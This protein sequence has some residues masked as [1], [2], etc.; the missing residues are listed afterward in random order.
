MSATSVGGRRSNAFFELACFSLWG[1][2]VSAYQQAK[3][4]DDVLYRVLQRDLSTFLDLAEQ[5]GRPLPRHVERELASYLACGIPGEGFT[6]L[7]CTDCPAVRVVP[8][9]CKGRGFCPSCV[10]RQMNQQAAHLVDRVFPEN[11]PVRQWVLT[12]P[13]PLRLRMAWDIDLRRAVHKVFR[14][15]VYRWYRRQAEAPKGDCGSVT[16]VQNFGSALNLN[17]HFHSIVLDGV[18]VWDADA[19]PV[20]QR[21]PPPTDAEVQ[22]VVDEIAVRVE[23]L[24]RRRGLLDEENGDQEE[25]ESEDGQL[26]MMA[27]SAAGRTA[28]GARA[29]R[30][31]RSLQGPPRP[32]GSLPPK[33]ASS[34]WFNLHAGVAIAPQDPEALER[35]IRYTAR[36][37]LSLDRVQEL[38]DGRVM[39]RFKRAWANG[40]AAVILTGVELLER[41]AALVPRPRAQRVLYGGILASAAAWRSL[42]VPKRPGGERRSRCKHKHGSK[43][44]PYI[45]W[46]DLLFRVFG[47]DAFKCHA[48]DG[49]MRV[50]AVVKGFWAT[51]RVLG[52]LRISPSG[53][54][55]SR[56]PPLGTP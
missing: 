45:K 15:V 18:F 36:P 56:A 46:K 41:L 3:R 10:G 35:L 30:R 39:V 47:V 4:G 44:S 8:F 1:P 23:R 28:L 13:F 22:E 5:R 48:C 31:P 53:P 33:C 43:D 25:E 16:F 55:P 49:R 37:P 19:G 38:D 29:G 21:V 26:L 32:R 11:V 17:V 27:A 51:R 34:G 42:V 24:L 20:F 54:A 40:T 7:R 2:A 6:L 9:T 14:G 12:F 52:C 50:H